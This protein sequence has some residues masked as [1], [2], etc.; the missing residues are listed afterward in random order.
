VCEDDALVDD[1]GVAVV[2]TRSTVSGDTQVE[3]GVRLGV[4]GSHLVEQVDGTVEVHRTVVEQLVLD[5]EGKA[6]AIRIVGT[7]GTQILLARR[8]TRLGI[9]E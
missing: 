9:D 2:D 1:K 8:S 4:L 7:S 5:G 6:E 3:D